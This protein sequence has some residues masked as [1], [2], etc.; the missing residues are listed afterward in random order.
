MGRQLLRG[1]GCS[2]VDAIPWFC[3]RTCS[4]VIGHYDVYLTR[5]HITAAYSLYLRGALA[6]ALDLQVKSTGDR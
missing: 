6:G 4:F 2:H 1:Q 3:A 5:D